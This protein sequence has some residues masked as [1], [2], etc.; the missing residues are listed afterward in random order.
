MSSDPIIA[1]IHAARE[2]LWNLYHGSAEEMAERQRQW[3]ELHP[4]RM[5]DVA[6]WWRERKA[7]AQESSSK[8]DSGH[9]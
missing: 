3:Q 1:E 9:P 6:R 2:H 4:D 7:A 5:I 8:V